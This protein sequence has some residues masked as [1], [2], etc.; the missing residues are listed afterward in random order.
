MK[1]ISMSLPLGAHCERH[2]S[3]WVGSPERLKPMGWLAITSLSLSPA[4]GMNQPSS[5]TP[6]ADGKVISSS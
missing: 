5:G 1:L 4:A 3:R 2:G 6:Y